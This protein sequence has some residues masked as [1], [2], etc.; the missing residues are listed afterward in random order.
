MAT[1]QLESARPTLLDLAQEVMAKLELAKK[2]QETFEKSMQPEKQLSVCPVSGVY[3]SSTD[4]EQRQA[5]HL[6]G[7]QYQVHTMDLQNGH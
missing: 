4:N 3:M 5:D 1:L 2:V 7:K 6:S